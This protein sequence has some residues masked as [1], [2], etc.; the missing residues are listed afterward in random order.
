MMK[1]WINTILLWA[2]VLSLSACNAVIDNGD[3]AVVFAPSG[4][5]TS[6]AYQGTLFQ[7]VSGKIA[8]DGYEVSEIQ[9]TKEKD[10]VCVSKQLTDSS[11][12]TAKIVERFFPTETSVR[13]ACEVIGDK[14][15]CSIPIR[16]EMTVPAADSVWFWTTWGRPGINL[17]EVPDGSFRN[18]LKLMNLTSNNWLN[19]LIPIPFTEAEY[20]YG[21]PA[22]TNENPRI[23]YCPIYGDVISVP[24]AVAV[25]RRKGNGISFVLALDDY[26]QDL[27]LKT[28]EEGRIVFSRF[29]HRLVDSNP[30]RFSCDIVGHSDDWRESLSWIC[31]RYPEYFEPENPSVM[32]MGGTGAYTNH[33]V[34]F[35]IEK[36]KRMAFRVNWRASF[37]FPYMGMFLPPVGEREEWTRFGGDKTSRNK[38]AEYAAKMKE[39]GFFV[40]N[41]FN[42]TEFGAYVNPQEP[43]RSTP[44]GE[45]WKNCND[46][47]YGVLKEAILRVPDSMNLQGCIYPKTRNGGMF[48]TWEEGVVMDCGVPVYADFLMEQMRR[49][50]DAVPEAVGFCIDRMDWLRMFNLNRDDGRSWFNNQPVSSM[51]L[52]WNEFM[53]RFAEKAHQAKKVIFVNNHTKRVDLL[54]HAD[55]I[56]DE[57]T[58]YESPLNTTS[59]LTLKK[60]FLGWTPSV[61]DL[62]SDGPD[63]F[64][65]KYLYMG[66]FPMCPFPGNDHSIRPDEWGDQ[67]YLDYGPLMRLLQGRQWILEKNPVRVTSADAKAN[68]FQTPEGYVVPI[69]FAQ[70]STAH[71]ALGI[72]KQGGTWS[73]EAW[74]PGNEI[75]EKLSDI[76]NRTGEVP[77]IE[78]PMS[79]GCAMLHIRKK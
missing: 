66:A 41:Y 19:P 72:L 1:P 12:R 2:G 48:F 47:L 5:I 60:P 49:H 14:K 51:I 28:S 11:G 33:D 24:V 31:N 38:M 65:Q 79:R 4:E 30:I 43:P 76:Q 9:V 75:P 46:Y 26:I 25:D 17:D 77:E 68:V 35:D 32:S 57:F 54:R 45:E 3:V 67:Q 78:I 58:N 23:A 50:I 64:F 29:H 63:N 21:A 74:Y 62:R 73:V 52:S 40:L 53:E 10:T 16:M 59:F 42:V 15:P 71:I 36:M 18:E 8:L 70:N 6:I 20:H 55:G 39:M 37:D 13:W 56:F 44:P 27:S 34:D 69:V 22:V 61:G 7:N